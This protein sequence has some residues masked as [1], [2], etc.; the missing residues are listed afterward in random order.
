MGTSIIPKVTVKKNFH[1]LKNEIDIVGRSYVEV[2][3][4]NLSCPAVSQICNFTLSP[5]MNI[6][7]ILKSTPMVVI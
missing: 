4:R 5:L 1:N 2:M 3:V 6:V 7:R